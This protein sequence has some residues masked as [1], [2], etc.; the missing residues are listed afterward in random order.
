MLLREK[1]LQFFWVEMGVKVTN[2]KRMTGI[3]E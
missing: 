2:V 3:Q 1:F